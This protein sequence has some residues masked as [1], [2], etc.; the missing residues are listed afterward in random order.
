MAWIFF[1]A[2]AFHLVGFVAA[3]YPA[4]GQKGQPLKE[5]M[6]WYHST[7]EIH[8]EIADISMTCQGAQIEVTTKTRVNSG[9]A[10]GQEVALD[11][12]TVRKP[13]A[14]ARTKAM[15]VF[16]EHAREIVS[17]ESALDLLRTLCGHGSGASRVSEL[18]DRVEFTVVPN[19]NPL[20]RKKVEEGYYCKR[21]NEDSVDLNRNWG[22]DHRGDAAKFAGDE[23]DPGPNGFSEPETQILRDLAEEVH[24]D[25]YLSIHSGAYLL[26]APYGYTAN[27]APGNEASMVEILGPI[28]QRYCGGQCPYG[29]LAELIGYDSM[30]CDVDYMAEHLNTPFAYTWEIYVGD[31]I[32]KRYIEEA[33]D[34]TQDDKDE[35]SLFQTDKSR[36][37][38][39]AS[40]VGHLRGRQTGAAKKA[41]LKSWYERPESEQ[42]WDDCIEQFTPRT[43]EATRA[44]VDTWTGAY[45]DLADAVDVKR[46]TQQG[47]EAKTPKQVKPST[48]PSLSL[49]FDG[50]HW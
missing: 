41:R 42:D 50:M 24:P 31:E 15:F 4:R 28:S 9:S 47:A 43:S 29:G 7:Q 49:A 38:K 8:D 44:V 34:R 21:T 16:G 26:G 1:L 5:K 37:R 33:Q 46:H 36:K 40:A 10:A 2:L 25:V 32:R 17:P 19:A 22:D 23:M 30:G 45:L 13:G 39:G 12:L 48:P 20:G 14:T 18:L 11:V 35:F 6:P 27:K 3:K